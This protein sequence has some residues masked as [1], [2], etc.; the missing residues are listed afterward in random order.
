MSCNAFGRSANPVRI[1]AAAAFASFAAAAS[2]GQDARA[3]FSTRADGS[4]TTAV[5]EDAGARLYLVVE[6]PEQP[7]GMHAKATLVTGRTVDGDIPDM[8]TVVLTRMNDFRYAAAVFVERRGAFMPGDGKLHL[9][10]GDRIIA[11]YADPT[12]PASQAEAKAEFTGHPSLEV[13]TEFQ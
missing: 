4:D 12:R 13:S 3:Y 5:Y 2:H 7:L 10:S 1:I 6:A 9:E 8:E 11:T